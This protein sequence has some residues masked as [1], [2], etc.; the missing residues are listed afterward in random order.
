MPP[1]STKLTFKSFE[2]SN[3]FYL[4]RPELVQEF[5]EPLISD[6]NTRFLK[7]AKEESAII[8]NNKSKLA[9]LF[10]LKKIEQFSKNYSIQIPENNSKKTPMD[11]MNFYHEKL[12]DMLQEIHRLFINKSIF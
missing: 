8:A 1:E 6:S 7:R 9:T 5:D 2:N 12:K 10:L 3:F 4:F 11:Q